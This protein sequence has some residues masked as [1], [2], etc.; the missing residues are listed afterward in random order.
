MHQFVS[1]QGLHSPG[2]GNV[3]QKGHRTHEER[4]RVRAVEETK[5]DLV[6]GPLVDVVKEVRVR[7]VPLPRPLLL[8]P[9]LEALGRRRRRR[10]LRLVLLPS[11]KLALV[12]VSVRRPAFGLGIF[13]RSLHRWL[14]AKHNDFV[15]TVLVT[16]RYDTTCYET[17]NEPP[18]NP[19]SKDTKLRLLLGFTSRWSHDPLI[20]FSHMAKANHADVSL[21]V[22]TAMARK[23]TRTRTKAHDAKCGICRCA[24]QQ[25]KQECSRNKF[26]DACIPCQRKF[27]KFWNPRF[28]HVVQESRPRF[29]HAQFIKEL[30]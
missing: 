1:T 19:V 3:D 24:K 12:Q 7:A 6:H 21:L 29:G 15:R 17:P 27:V 10:L 13:P 26:N 4:D 14:D 5:W 11:V 30:H 25:S 28:T 9:G 22:A 16:K 8:L 2:K 18:S 20:P 23:Q